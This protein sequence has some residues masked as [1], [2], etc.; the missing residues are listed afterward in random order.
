MC[1]SIKYS[2]AFPSSDPREQGGAD[3]CYMGALG[4]DFHR[5]AMHKEEQPPLFVSG[6][7]LKEQVWRDQ[8]N[9]EAGSDNISAEG[10]ALGRFP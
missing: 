2:K 1:V 4:T 10:F 5:K 7:G 6:W 9:K 8:G 3:I